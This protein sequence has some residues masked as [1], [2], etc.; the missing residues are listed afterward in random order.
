[1]KENQTDLFQWPFCKVNCIQTTFFRRNRLS[2]SRKCPYG[3]KNGQ[4]WTGHAG[5]PRK[6]RQGCRLL[7]EHIEHIFFCR[8]SVI[9]NTFITRKGEEGETEGRRMDLSFFSKCEYCASSP[10][11]LFM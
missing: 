5:G 1:M 8:Q 6:K 11:E 9:E 4:S 3:Q 2:L 7:R 10:L